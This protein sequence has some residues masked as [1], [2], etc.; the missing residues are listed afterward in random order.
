MPSLF[1]FAPGLIGHGLETPSVL[2]C[3]DQL[4]NAAEKNAKHSW[5]RFVKNFEIKYTM[6]NVNKIMTKYDKLSHVAEFS[7]GFK[8]SKTGARK[9]IISV[10]SARG[11]FT[12]HG[13]EAKKPNNR[14]K[15]LA[16]HPD[17]QKN[18]PV[19]PFPEVPVQQRNSRRTA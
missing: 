2:P 11:K 15:S 1:F 18:C 8:E 13:G 4:H 9:S 16:D 3:L 10:I 6:T 19:H 7:F 17:I 5:P 12:Y 14:G